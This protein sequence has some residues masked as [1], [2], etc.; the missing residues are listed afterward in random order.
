MKFIIMWDAGY[1]EN[2]ETIEAETLEKAEEHASA[3][4]ME[5]ME[6]N[7]SYE[8]KEWTEELAEEYGV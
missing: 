3:C 4:C 2:W 8:A 1:G 7:A 5:E 6:S